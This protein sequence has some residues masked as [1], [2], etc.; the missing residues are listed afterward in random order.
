MAKST[1]DSTNKYKLKFERDT[2]LLYIKTTLLGYT[3]SA[4][5]G[6]INFLPTTIQYTLESVGIEIVDKNYKEVP[7]TTAKR[8][9]AAGYFN[10]EY[11]NPDLYF[12]IPATLS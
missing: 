1:N 11:E 10:T 4:N 3:Y 12:L 9:Y 6:T 7:I 2:L 5:Q 8:S